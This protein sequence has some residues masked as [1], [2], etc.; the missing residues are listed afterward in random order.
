MSWA[1]IVILAIPLVAVLISLVAGW[2]VARA[3]TLVAGAASLGAGDRARRVGRA[4][5]CRANGSAAGCGSTRSAPCSCIATGLLYAIAGVFSVGYLQLDERE[6]DFSGFARRYFA[7]LNLFGWT[8]LLVP[9]ASDFGTLWVAVEL[10]TIVSALLV[11]IDRTDAALEASW[12]YVLI[13]SCG[14]GIALLSIIVLYATGTQVLGTAYV[15]RFARFLVHGHALSRD[16]IRLSFVLA[17]VG[18]GTKVGF[19]PTHTWLPDAH[20]EAPAPVSAMLSGALLASAFYA[21]LRFFQVA[22]AAGQRSFAEHVLIVFGAISLIA[23]SL[24]VLRQR[25]FKRLLAYSSIEHM[26]VIALGIGFGAP[27][28]VAGALLHVI[29]HASAKGLAFF[30]AGSLLRGYDTKE[31]DEVTGAATA[32]PWTG[33]DVPRRRARAVRPAALRSVPQRVS[34]RRRRIRQAAVRRRHAAVGVRQP[35]VLRSP[36]ARRPDGPHPGQRDQD[37]R[38]P[39]P[40][41]RRDERVDGRRDARLPVRGRRAR[42][43]PAI[44]AVDADRARRPPPIGADTM[45]VAEQQSDLPDYLPEHLGGVREPG[46]AGEVRIRVPP[47][48]FGRA[49]QMLRRAG[50]RF[51][52]VLLAGTPEPAIVGAFAM[53]GDLVVLRAPTP[54]LDPPTYTALG[55][56]WP[57]A[58]WAEQELADRFGVRPV[59]LVA[60]RHLTRPDAD[61]LDHAVAG[62]DVFSLPYGPVRSGVFEAIQFLI[63]TGGEDVTRAPD[64][65]V[66]QAP[67]ARAADRRADARARR[68]TSPSGSPGISSVAYALGV[69]A[70][71]RAGTRRRP[72]RCRPS[73]G[74]RSTPSSSGWPAIS[75]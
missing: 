27:L 47:L 73:A 39:D 8:M 9:L 70:G 45:S 6:A 57:A 58:R 59:G 42:G 14:L 1:L 46:P 30:G 54:P 21:I 56:F 16:A 22:V 50:A 51:V 32:M 19:V 49:G 65:T 7:L 10:T 15:P 60:L 2:R 17:V 11:A 26:G 75:T 38:R 55:P 69:L 53:R 25:N 68:C 61:A 12:K 29:T 20:S 74:A 31:V 44:G 34:D 71:G 33:P 41:P 64:T 35:R 67:R 24:F 18:F 72:R 62:L 37:Q 36:L 48:A 52:T 13:A 3:A 63:E 43:A 23:A 4:R 5:Q 28:A 40:H 66:L